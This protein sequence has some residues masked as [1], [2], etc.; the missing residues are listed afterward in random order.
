MG[1]Y[2][3][4]DRR[5]KERVYVDKRW[6]DGGRYK[7]VQPNLTVARK[8]LARIQE[9]IAMG[10]WRE[11]RE[12]LEV[13]GDRPQ[14]IADLSTPYLKHCRIKNRRPDFKEW[15]IKPVLRIVGSVQVNRFTRKHAREFMDKRALEVA[16]A[17]VNRSL[18]VLKNMLT[19]AV[20]EGILAT[21]P[22][23]RF[24][25][26]PEPERALR[27][28]TIE[29]ERHLIECVALFDPVIAAY[30]AV[31]GESGLRKS[32]GLR[33]KWHHIDL[34]RRQVSVGLSKNGKVR[35]VPLTDFACQWLCTLIR[36]VGQDSVFLRSCGKPWRD[37]RGPFKAGAKKASLTWVGF[38]DL[39]HFRATQWVRHGMDLRTVKELLGHFDIQTTIRYA[40][41]APD[42]ATRS[43]HEIEVAE[44]RELEFNRYDSGRTQNQ[45]SS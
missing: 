25:L 44:K 5:G 43:V 35:H 32:E 29:E 22:L 2:K 20:N 3:H 38:H 10:T 11:L 36:Y 41:F 18:A 37:P 1:V 14:T 9:A 4:K 40:H 31:L 16:P 27:V 45:S 24:G 21:H 6:P 8:T 12:E 28:M 26:L 23:S 17:T 34:A 15:A 42:H 19:F 33:L 39:R 13:C 7:R 30:A